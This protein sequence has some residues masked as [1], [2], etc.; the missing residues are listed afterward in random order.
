MV[1]KI[2]STVPWP[3]IKELHPII[4]RHDLALRTKF[5]ANRPQ[6]CDHRYLQYVNSV[7]SAADRPDLAD[8]TLAIFAQFIRITITQASVRGSY[9]A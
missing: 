9:N 1:T 2:M 6:G 3:P 7:D 5:T 8:L 4:W